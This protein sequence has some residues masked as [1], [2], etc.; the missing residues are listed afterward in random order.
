M[1]IPRLLLAACSVLVLALPAKAAPVSAL[2]AGEIAVEAYLYTFPLVTMELTRRQVTNVPT[3]G[4]K[5]G[6]GPMNALHHKREYPDASFRDVVRPNFDTLYS[7]AWMDLRREPMIVSIPDN[8]ERYYLMPL[9]D[10]WT[11]VFA[12]PGSRTNGHGPRHFAVVAP[13]WRGKL[14]AGVERIDAPTSTVFMPG[15]SQTNG[16]ADYAAVHVFQDGMR[17]TPL[18]RWGKT[19]LA[20]TNK[21]IN[22]ATDMTTPPKVQ[23]MALQAD[24]F[25]RLAAEL[26]A[27]HPAHFTD[28]PVLARIARIG[29][30]AGKPFDLKAQDPVVQRALEQAV[31]QAQKMMAMQPLRLAPKVNGWVM[32]TE[33]IGNFGNSYLTRAAIALAGLGANPPEDSVYAFGYF[34]ADGKPLHSAARYTITFDKDQLPPARAFWSVTM[35]DNASFP[36]A[37]P[38]NRFALGDRDPLKRNADGSTTLYVQASSPG[39]ELES[40]WLP[41]PANSAFNVTLRAYYPRQAMLAGQWHMPPVRK[42]E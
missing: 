23:V 38:I 31:G 28:H 1:N 34:D 26:M 30:V 19:P 25:F 4:I 15:R 37:N 24:Q 33:N 8:R 39:P 17:L 22:P 40:N 14:P 13:G 10:M 32:P 7:F 3:I 12:S 29:L 21:A 16:T 35:Y 20:V 11:E 2:E 27:Q 9:M 41:A 36:V 6:R 18:S 42:V 5:S